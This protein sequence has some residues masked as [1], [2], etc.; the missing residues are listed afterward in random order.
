MSALRLARTLYYK[1]TP[2]QQPTNLLVRIIVASARPA[3]SRW[4]TTVSLSSP[5]HDIAELL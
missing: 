4:T 5:F 1:L 3:S 2:S